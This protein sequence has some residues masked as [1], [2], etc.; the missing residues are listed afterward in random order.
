MSVSL[1]TGLADNSETLETLEQ[2]QR[3]SQGH[4]Q[5]SQTVQPSDSHDIFEAEA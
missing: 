2:R 4:E 3:G 5:W 1:K